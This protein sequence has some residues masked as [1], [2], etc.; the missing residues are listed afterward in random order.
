ME[1]NYIVEGSHETGRLHLLQVMREQMLAGNNAPM[2]TDL[3]YDQFLNSNQLNDYASEVLVKA[4]QAWMQEFKHFTCFLDHGV[5]ES[6]R[7][8][9]NQVGEQPNTKIELQ[10]MA[11]MAQTYPNVVTPKTLKDYD[12]LCRSMPAFVDMTAR[13]ADTAPG[14]AHE[15]L[16]QHFATYYNK[17]LYQIDGKVPEQMER[18]IFESPFAG[19]MA[20]NSEYA[21]SC[22]VKLML[23]EHVAP[24]ASHLLYTRMLNDNDPKEREIGIDAGLEYG[25]HAQRTIIAVDR[26]LSTGMKYGI[27]NAESANRPLSFMTISPNDTIKQEVGSLRDIQDLESWS[28]SRAEQV[29][30]QAKE[31]GW[32]VEPA[33]VDYLDPKIRLDER[34]EESQRFKV[35]P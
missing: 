13:L 1:L 4:K 3:F 14:I 9:L 22:I 25:R 7:A 29:S 33:G 23:A 12:Q 34:P 18:V 2:N 32:L 35:S 26:G 24:M 15:H 11:Q 16:P 6:V 28:Q 20:T 17:P 8:F 10:F 5:D 31:G 19:D 30:P 27:K 21:A